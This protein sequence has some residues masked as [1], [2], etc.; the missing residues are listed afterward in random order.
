MTPTGSLFKIPCGS[1]G[2]GGGGGSVATSTH[3]TWPA[4]APPAP[5]APL[6]PAA[7]AAAAA[8]LIVKHEVGHE[9]QCKL[10]QDALDTVE[11]EWVRQFFFQGRSSFLTAKGY[12]SS[13]LLV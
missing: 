7:A 10:E 8:A 6:A 2:G 1:A 3:P 13:S 12:A 11:F 5:P 4:Q 9:A